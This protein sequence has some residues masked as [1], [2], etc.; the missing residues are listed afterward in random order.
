MIDVTTN[1]APT[2]SD[3]TRPSNSSADNPENWNFE[4]PTDES[5][6][7]EDNPKP[8]DEGTDDDR[9][10]VETSEGQETDE[11]T[12]E[13]DEAPEPALIEDDS[14]VVTLKSGEKVSIAELR[15]G[16]LRTSDYTRKTTELA[17]SRKQVETVAQNLDR[18]ANAFAQ[19]LVNQLPPKP[20]QS[21]MFTDPQAHYRQT[22]MYNEALAQVQS[23]VEAS[24]AAK[25]AAKA[26]TEQ[27]RAELL[28]AENAKLAE[29]FPTTSDPSGREKFFS[30]ATEAARKLGYSDKELA[31][32]TDHRA[33]GLAYYAKIGMEAEAAKKSVARKVVN[34]PPVQAPRRQ[35]AGG[36]AQGRAYAETRTRFLKSGSIHD[37]VKLDF[38]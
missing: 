38:E 13:T 14:A 18:T 17:N 10:P 26:V 21:L 2:G 31:D 9:E 11:L 20:D 23:I 32:I 25:D 16:F 28:S 15:D 19:M 3:S 6:L 24:T 4:D 12:E 34:A 8:S 7:V 33:F 5:P 36:D 1:P 29:A 30:N 22:V 37:A 27:E 35:A